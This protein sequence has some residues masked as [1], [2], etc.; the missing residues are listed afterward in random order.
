MKLRPIV[1]GDWPRLE[2][3]V[4]RH[5]G[6]SHIPDRRFHEHW[7]RYPFAAKGEAWGGRLLERPD[8]SLAGALTVIVLPA[9]FAGRETRLGYLS[10]GVV[11][12]DARK[13]GQGA[14]LYLWAYRAY[15]LVLAMAGN[16][17]SSPLNALMGRDIPG[18]AMRRFLRLNRP[19]A[20][21]LCPAGEAGKVAVLPAPPPAPPRSLSA[22]WVPQAPD[23]YDPLWRA[24]RDGLTCS[25]DKTAAYLRWRCGAPYTDYRTL[26]LRSAGRLIGLAVCRYQETPAGP[27]ARVTEMIA[28]PGDAAGVWAAVAE[29]T[30]DAVMTDFLVVGTVHDTGLAEGG[31][32]EA[33]A[34][35]GLDRLPHLLS[36]VEHRQ[37]TSV[38]TLGGPLALADQS[39]RSAE[40]V[41]FTK[42]DGDR[43]WPT[44]WDLERL[45]VPDKAAAN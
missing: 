7:F 32:T 26:A 44:Q 17:L 40:A 37:W 2:D 13:E 4:R 41:Y 19:E 1:D 20:L 5:F 42:G 28:R 21:T 16:A 25:V 9:W 35:N 34:G 38:F 3:F 23:D 18:V 27:V 15:P 8:G 14:A 45:R 12:E 24:V 6:F 31:F 43:D 10:T 29:A 39:W 33:T 22:D 11:E 36:P 30:R